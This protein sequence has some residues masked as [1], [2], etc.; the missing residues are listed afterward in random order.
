MVV[1]GLLSK[2]G[3]YGRETLIVGRQQFEDESDAVGNPSEEITYFDKDLS[4][5]MEVNSF[6]RSIQENLPVSEC[7]SEDALRV[8]RIIDQAYRES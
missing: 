6:V 1:K 7:S 3:S 8:M 5:V 2:S 4:W